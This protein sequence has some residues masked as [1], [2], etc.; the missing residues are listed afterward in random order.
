MSG[1]SIRAAFAAAAGL[2]LAAAGVVQPAV[3]F[4]VEVDLGRI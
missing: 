1:T 2:T 3:P 4:S